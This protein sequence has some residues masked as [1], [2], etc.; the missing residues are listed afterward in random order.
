MTLARLLYISKTTLDTAS[1]EFE[2]ELSNI[3]MSCVKN[4]AL[5]DITGVLTCDRGVFI[6]ALEGPPATLTQSFI[7]ISGDRRHTDVELVHFGAV[8]TRLFAG[9]SMG[10]VEAAALEHTEA[11]RTALH[12][13]APSEVLAALSV[14]AHGHGISERL[15]S[16]A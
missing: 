9:W 14:L 12:S 1:A 13:K 15:G 3:L 11:L 7:R 2:I 4:N 6:Q 5:L 8:E 16:A 10:F